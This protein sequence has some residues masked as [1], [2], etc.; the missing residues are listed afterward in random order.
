MLGSHFST[1]PSGST[2]LHIYVRPRPPGRQGNVFCRG[3]VC[4]SDTEIHR[5][6]KDDE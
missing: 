1:T 3:G 5:Q 4:G 2:H 6:Q